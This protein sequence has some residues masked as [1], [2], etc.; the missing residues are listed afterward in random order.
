[1]LDFP[2]A[3]FL[4]EFLSLSH[5]IPSNRSHLKELSD[6]QRTF[7]CNTRNL[8]KFA[9]IDSR[10]FNQSAQTDLSSLFAMHT[11]KDI[12]SQTD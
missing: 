3:K 1:M 9:K 4:I 5:L 12:I 10:D 8:I 7:C 2:S 6:M 11:L